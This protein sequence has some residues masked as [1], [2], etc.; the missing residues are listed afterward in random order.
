MRRI[1]QDFA[2]YPVA[3]GRLMVAVVFSAALHIL[4]LHSL[5]LRPAIP[6]ARQSSPIH[7]RLVSA[8]TA[9]IPAG[10]KRVPT[11]LPVATDNAVSLPRE[12]IPGLSEKPDPEPSSPVENVSL[13]IP[14]LPE[15]PDLIH[16]AAKDLDIYPQLRGAL[17][18]DYPESAFAQKIAGTVT[19]LV[20]VD[21]AGRVTE[22][23]VVDAVPE[24]LFDDSAQQ[25]LSRA[26]FIPAQRDGRIVRSRILVSVNFDPEKP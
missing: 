23:A 20:L 19:L 15:V 7:A 10:R 4:L 11:P 9:P 2:R 14:A 8:E 3:E 24:G 25:A 1:R 17:N 6:A 21:E 13:A 22:T 18:P 5:V 26:A 16:Y 12:V